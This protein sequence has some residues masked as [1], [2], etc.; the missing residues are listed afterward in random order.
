MAY[1]RIY[2]G[3]TLVEQRELVSARTMIGRTEDN[4][5][6]LPSDGVSKCHAIIEKNGQDFVIVDN[7]SANGVLVNGD[8]I[9]R[10]VLKY[11]D[12]MQIFDYVLKF[13]AVSALKGDMEGGFEPSPDQPRVEETMEFALA[14][15]AALRRKVKV[16][17]LI[18]SAAGMRKHPLDKVNFKIGRGRDCD[19]RIKGWFAPKLAATLQRRNDAFYVIPERRGKVF[20]N[21][22]GVSMETK[23][24]DDDDL[25]VRN[26]ALK[27]RFRLED[28]R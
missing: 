17:S 16:A 28:D 27:F 9:D 6:V 3:D 23:L 22:K 25:Q 19:I 11:W 5:I 20:I 13:M 8:R 26:L 2:L 7:A 21:G 10:H 24:R 18:E 1:V 4:D 15:L 14:D 12:E